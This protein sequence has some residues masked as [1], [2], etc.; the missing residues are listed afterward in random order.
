MDFA[1]AELAKHRRALEGAEGEDAVSAGS[2]RLAGRN[3][4]ID[5]GPTRFDAGARGFAVSLR[6][7]SRSI[8]RLCVS[9]R[10]RCDRK[11]GRVL[12]SG[13]LC[14]CRS[15][16]GR[17]DLTRPGFAPARGGVTRFIVE[18][19][20]V[21][22]VVALFLAW[23]MSGP[24]SRFR[25]RGAERPASVSAAAGRSAAI[26]RPPTEAR[27]FLRETA[28]ARASERAV[29]SASRPGSRGSL[30]AAVCEA[31]ASLD[32][33]SIGV[34]NVEPSENKPPDLPTASGR[35]YANGGVSASIT[36]GRSRFVGGI[37][38]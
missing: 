27:V 33:M 4:A 32:G 1:G 22:L 13:T 17:G 20:W 9:R 29:G 36:A 25:F 5:F 24:G 12:C 8:W 15:A 18:A 3:Q 35:V 38:Q 31:H 21:T 6:R 26:Q 37:F 23:L 10:Y 30:S 7:R 34:F 11:D 16:R 14:I 28:A 2:E 19:A